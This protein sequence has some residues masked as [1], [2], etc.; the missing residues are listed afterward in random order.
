MPGM[1]RLRPGSGLSASAAGPSDWP[2][3][4][5]NHA[6][7]APS[8]AA[9]H[10]HRLAARGHGG[11]GRRR[12][13]PCAAH[14]ARCGCGGQRTLYADARGSRDVRRRQR[15]RAPL[16]ALPGAAHAPRRRRRER[17]GAGRRLR[18]DRRAAPVAAGGDRHGVRRDRRDAPGDAPPPRRGA[19]SAKRPGRHR[20]RHDKATARARR[21]A[22]GPLPWPAPTFQPC[23]PSVSTRPR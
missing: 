7:A 19:S 6:Q 8:R 18:R 16:R 15:D 3:T 12:P 22:T 9:S 4:E 5:A 14:R 21:I 17:G 23:C 10:A 13:R 2:P 20:W 1:Q 11:H